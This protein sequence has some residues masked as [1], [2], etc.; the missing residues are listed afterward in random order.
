M[1]PGKEVDEVDQDEVEERHVTAE[2]QHRD[3][4]DERRIR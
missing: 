1:Q 3:D 2:Q 4:N